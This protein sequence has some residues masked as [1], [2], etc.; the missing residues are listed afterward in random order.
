MDADEGAL[1]RDHHGAVGVGDGEVALSEGE[2]LHHVQLHHV[3]RAEMRPHHRQR[4]NDASGRLRPRWRREGRRRRHQEFTISRPPVQQ[5]ARGV[6]RR[7][8]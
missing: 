4:L 2:L 1:D 6:A 5:L 3:R 7:S 8:V